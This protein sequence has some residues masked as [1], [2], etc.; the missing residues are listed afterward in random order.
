MDCVLGLLFCGLLCNDRFFLLVEKVSIF[1]IGFNSV[2][3]KNLKRD[4][5]CKWILMLVLLY[6]NGFYGW[7]IIGGVRYIWKCFFYGIKIF[8]GY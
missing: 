6:N 7:R 4:W 8:V 1:I 2:F 3:V 5:N